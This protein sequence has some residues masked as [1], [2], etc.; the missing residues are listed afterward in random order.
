[1][2]ACECGSTGGDGRSSV[3]TSSGVFLDRTED[4]A[5]VL[6]AIEEKIAAVTFIPPSHGEDFNVLRYQAGQHYHSHM[7]TWSMH[8]SG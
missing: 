7:D 8:N 3:R 4:P 2:D 5:G 6:A 1:M